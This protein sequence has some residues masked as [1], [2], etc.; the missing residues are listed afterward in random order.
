MPRMPFVNPD[1]VPE[2]GRPLVEQIKRERGGSVIALYQML[3][4]SP[5]ICAG[6]LHLGTAVRYEASL[7]DGMRELIICRI[8]LL[9]R[10]RYEW[11]HHQPI[12]LKSGVTQV[13][14]DDLE[15]WR[16]SAAY[17]PAQRAALAYAEQV[18]Q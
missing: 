18:T 4:N 7:A 3:L 14:I 17:S 16:E 10:A 15:R 9:T 1:T 11:H 5:A 6:W 2:A 12:A 8:A 13:Q